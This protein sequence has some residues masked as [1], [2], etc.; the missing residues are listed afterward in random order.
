MTFAFEPSCGFGRHLVTVGGTVI[1]GEDGPE[2]LNPYTSR[3]LRAHEE[4]N[5]V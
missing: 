4:R 3:I 5:A 1:V 2:E